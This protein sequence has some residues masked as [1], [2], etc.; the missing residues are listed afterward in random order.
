M[1]GMNSVVMTGFIR[2]TKYVEVRE[3]LYKFTAKIELPVVIDNGS[4]H[5]EFSISY[6]IISWGDVAESM[7]E[8]VE[9]TP[10]KISGKLNVRSYDS[11][12]N[13]CGAP[14]RKYWTDIVVNNFVIIT[15]EGDM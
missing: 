8:L 6:F 4:E 11:K 5:K 2:N 15:D 12:C 1:L 3:D 13:A 9:G 7:K 14:V 10:I